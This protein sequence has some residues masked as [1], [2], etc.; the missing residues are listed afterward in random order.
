MSFIAATWNTQGCPL[1]GSSSK[2]ELLGHILEK[3]QI[4]MLQETGNPADWDFEDGKQGIFNKEWQALFCT[5]PAAF[6]LRCSVGLLIHKDIPVKEMGFV[7]SPLSYR[8]LVYAVLEDGGIVGSFHS[9]ASNSARM[10][11]KSTVGKLKRSGARW[12]LVGAD[13]NDDLIDLSFGSSSISSENISLL[14]GITQ[15]SGSSIDGFKSGGAITQFA[16]V[17]RIHPP[18]SSGAR[19]SFAS[20]HQALGAIFK[21]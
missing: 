20:D 7:T 10:D 11:W 18:G 14:G 21:I 5:D 3:A 6:N 2:K 17:F 13:F 12:W 9:I 1:N 15:K 4:V 19:F 8:P 16:S